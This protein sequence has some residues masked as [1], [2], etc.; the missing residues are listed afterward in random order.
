MRVMM[1]A[2]RAILARTWQS[3]SAQVSAP[4]PWS[5]HSC[6][7]SWV[8]LPWV[9]RMLKIG[10]DR[11]FVSVPARCPCLVVPLVKYVVVE[12][13]VCQLACL[14]SQSAHTHTHTHT[15]KKISCPWVQRCITKLAS[16]T[17]K[18]R[19]LIALRFICRT[20]LVAWSAVS[21]SR[22]QYPRGVPFL[23]PCQ[24][25]MKSS[26]VI[27]PKGV[28]SFKTVY[29]FMEWETIRKSVCWSGGGASSDW[30]VHVAKWLGNNSSHIKGRTRQW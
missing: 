3:S 9:L 23:G 2:T 29:L 22:K 8:L 12:N 25:N 28:N 17:F 6:W 19:S 18:G 13:M 16:D 27:L 11:V 10:L 26:L 24:W 1:R 21:N 30:R 5:C 15:H 14:R 7:R 4:W 20:A